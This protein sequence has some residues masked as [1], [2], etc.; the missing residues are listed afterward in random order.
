[1]AGTVIHRR[2][3]G[4]VL[5]DHHLID[6]VMQQSG[7]RCRVTLYFLD[8][9]DPAA[10]TAPQGGALVDAKSIGGSVVLSYQCPAGDAPVF[11]ISEQPVQVTPSPPEQDIFEGRNAFVAIRNGEP[12]RIVRDWLQFHIRTQDLQGV[13]LLDRAMPDSDPSFD[14]ELEQGLA[15]LD[16]PCTVMVLRSDTPL[17]KP[18]LPA[19]AHP[20]CAPGA[21]GKD[22]MKIPPPAPWAAPLGAL[23]W[24]E[25]AKDRFLGQARAAA[26]VEVH[27]LL[28]PEGDTVFDKSI[29]A[30]N[31]VVALIGQ[32]CYPWRLRN[33]REIH[34]GD[35]ICTQF[36]ADRG[37]KRWCIAPSKAPEDATWRLLRIGNAL[38]DPRQIQ[39]F[40][41]HMA[42]RHPTDSVST[43]VPKSSLIED[44]ALRRQAK[45]AFGHKALRAPKVKLRN[46]PKG[47]GRRAIITTMKNEGPFILEWL[48]Y[49][50]AIGFDD[51]L[52]YTNDC[53]DGTDT[54]LDLLMDKGIVTH[55]DNKF[56][57][58]RLRP[59]HAA[60][61]MAED[62]P[63]IQKAK[64]V[65]CIDVDEYVN[66]KVGDGTLDALF[67]AVPDANLISMTWRL[68]GNGDVAGFNDA[69]ITEQFQS[70]AHEDTRKPHQAWGFKTLFLNNGIFR[71]LGVHRPKGLNPQLWD[72]ITW[73][74]G[75][76]QVMPRNM[77]RNGW[78]STAATYGYDLVQLNHYAVR[79]AESFLV[80]RDRGRVN[81]VDRD[82]GLAY[83]FR[84]NNNV[85]T[86][87]SIRKNL[88]L[89]R[90]T[91]AKLMSDPE[92]AAAH[93]SAVTAHRT[94]ITELRDTPAYAHF[95]G[96]LTGDRLQK[97]S[98][99]HGH[100]GAHV[101]LA[102]PD[103]LPNDIT[104][105][106]PD[107]E[108]FFTVDLPETT[109]H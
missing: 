73:V 63:I 19:E 93:A 47:R 4:Q 74:N 106:D 3:T 62:E 96:Q 38:A 20:F 61:Q 21:P 36:D 5:G 25:I 83:W 33:A 9:A 71:K 40:H 56:Q 77:F 98:R 17:G 102:G 92:I 59:Q 39:R 54:M 81:H 43:I 27:D 53:T 44:D 10:I 16:Q 32:H 66:I 78:R 35:H 34:F 82:Q 51:I 52:V 18:N 75:S 88:P 69:P 95:Y 1:M 70:C 31:G 80:K 85:E 30:Q 13:V 90:G 49:H 46:V 8:G 101:Y 60:L 50:R 14:A 2:L 29:A 87:D 22:R 97:L 6:M 67:A 12:A 28:V 76:G 99:L 65:T 104:D 105:K 23:N 24:F 84:M 42:L 37:R 91:L 55:R 57:Q 11:F 68:F 58:M 100:F 7:D 103:S 45:D 94:K 64:W 86:D 41:R 79:S 89:M 109:K 15:A 26:N 48:A 107:A 72:K 108:W